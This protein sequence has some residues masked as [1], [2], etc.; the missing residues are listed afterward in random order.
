M[1]TQRHDLPSES[2]VWIQRSAKKSGEHGKGEGI[3]KETSSL[4]LV[5]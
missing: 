2:R 5:N 1:I 3:T 4:E